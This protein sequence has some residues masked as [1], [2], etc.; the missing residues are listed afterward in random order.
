MLVAAGCGG[1]GGKSL[2]TTTT[3]TTTAATV[4]GKYHYSPKVI[5]SF[6][7][8]CTQGN[9]AKKD[10]CGCVIDK[11]SNSVSTRDFARI[12]RTGK[13]VPR[14]TRAIRRATAACR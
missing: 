13:A 6:M 4:S 7:R 2:A 14:V 8:S 5:N 9:S 1:A 10:F 11:L 3:S 12:A